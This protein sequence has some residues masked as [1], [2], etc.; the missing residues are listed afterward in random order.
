MR[1][2][3][4]TIFA[5][6]AFALAFTG[7]VWAAGW[8]DY[9]KAE[10]EA[11]QNDG[12]LI[13]VDVYADWCPTCKAQKPHLDDVAGEPDM[14]GA[15]LVRVDYDTQKEFLAAHR[16][17]RQSTILLFAGAE[18]TVRIVAE[19]NG[20]RLKSSILAGIPNAE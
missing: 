12:R 14:A 20:E 1:S 8:T 11:A 16:I 15:L 4:R 2:T 13:L 7:S 18:E 9:S 17:P 10:F 3:I 19:T 6:I 5:S